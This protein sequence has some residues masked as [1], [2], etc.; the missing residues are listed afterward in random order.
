MTFGS[1]GFW[2][3]SVAV[4]TTTFG[5]FEWAEKSLKR[6]R[7]EELWQWLQSGVLEARMAIW[8]D[9]FVAMFDGLFGEQH[10]S[11][12]CFLRSVIM[13]VVMVFT[14][15]C[16]WYFHAAEIDQ[17]YF[18]EYELQYLV[19][20]IL[21]VNVLPDYLSLLQTRAILH[22]MGAGPRP[23]RIITVLLL[24]LIAS[25]AIVFVVGGVLRGLVHQL[26]QGYFEPIDLIT[27]WPIQMMSLFFN[28]GMGFESVRGI[29]IGVFL[30]SALW[31]SVWVWLFALVSV[32]ARSRGTVTLLRNLVFRWVKV[33]ETP[34]RA[35][36][37]VATVIVLFG[38]GLIYLVL[39]L[40]SLSG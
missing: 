34:Y 5:L 1:I 39:F 15:G 9:L 33:E 3:G 36:G 40:V 12:R 38:Y 28:Y 22:V 35:I 25:M 19:L 27:A 37:V 6:E 23:R 13:S 16:I 11:F 32:L 30:Y 7:A 2:A 24:D 4:A 31:T 10:L 26:T 18:W 21:A 17:A 14:L 8:P 20:V 29:S